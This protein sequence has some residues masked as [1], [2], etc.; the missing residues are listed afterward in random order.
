MPFH[1]CRRY[2]SG[3]GEAWRCLCSAGS[4]FAQTGLLGQVRLDGLAPIFRFLHYLGNRNPHPGLS[5]ARAGFAGRPCCSA[6]SGFAGTSP[7][8]VLDEFSEAVLPKPR[9]SR[10][11]FCKSNSIGP[12]PDNSIDSSTPR[13]RVSPPTKKPRPEIRSRLLGLQCCRLIELQSTSMRVGGRLQSRFDS[14]Q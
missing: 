7:A 11:P 9:H 3:R 14:Q 13:K 12:P 5:R 4:W 2:R 10:H 6:E 8:S 1:N